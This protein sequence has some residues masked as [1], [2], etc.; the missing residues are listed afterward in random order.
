MT[1]KVAAVVRAG[2][3]FGPLGRLE[4]IDRALV[5]GATGT[6][7]LNVAQTLLNFAVTLS[8]SHLLGARGLGAYAYAFAW[9][10]VLAVPS[11]LGLTPLVI[12]NVAAYRE[13]AEWGL[14]RGFLARANQAVVLSSALLVGGG[15]AVALIVN[16]SRSDLLHPVLVGLL[17][18]PILAVT[19]IR[20]AV[21]QG[22]GRVVLGRLPETL[23]APALFLVLIG[24]AYRLGHRY[25]SATW[26]IGLQ[27]TALFAA[28]LIGALMLFRLLPHDVKTIG[29]EHAMKD[30]VRSALP[31]LLFSGAQALNAQV[32]VIL[33][34]ALKGPA[35]AG[36]FSVAVRASGLVTFFLFAVRYPLA[37]MVA[38]LHAR[39]ETALLERT[40][41]RAARVVFL[42]SLPVALGVVVF[43]R[44]LL[45]LFGAEFKVGVTALILI[46][47]GQV[48]FAAMAFAGTVL[49]MTGNEA[50]LVRGVIV[51]ALANLALN[52]L[53]IPPFGL[54]GAA[55]GSTLAMIA[56]N[57]CLVYFARRRAGV[58]S[59][60]FGT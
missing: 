55:A 35:D 47:I 43:A 17:M 29:A 5:L 3:S 39:G 16:G 21:M 2:A 12:R 31:L 58:R 46:T 1:G 24:C 9:S 34:G 4:G 28:Y 51:G 19:S 54:N 20:Q 14:L 60:V 57:V 15:A 32:E 11:V 33:L 56:M 8:L 26:V 53:L 10:S 44:P 45:A 25:S 59:S 18:V 30:W 6:M 48:S 13:R 23:I 40:V 41:R 36:I 49:V 37:P 27:V 22:L 42:A 38:R 7:L 52:A 50:W